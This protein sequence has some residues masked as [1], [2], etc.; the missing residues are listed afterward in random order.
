MH[1]KEFRLTSNTAKICNK[2]LNNSKIYLRGTKE[3][4]DFSKTY[5][6]STD[7]QQL[8][9]FPT[10]DSVPLTLELINNIK[11]P[12][13]LVVPDATWSQAVKFHK[14]EPILAKMQK[15]HLTNHDKSIYELRSQ[16]HENGVC[17]LEA[18]AFALDIIENSY[19]KEHLIST[20][21]IM[22]I[23]NLRA[24]QKIL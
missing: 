19:A 6:P 10:E 8:Y 24:R 22:N 17:T 4:Q 20:L 18:V 23:Q 16:I 15:I 7:H 13:E 14:R 12:I 3:S 11:K 2:V 5:S 1:F 21:K 9:L